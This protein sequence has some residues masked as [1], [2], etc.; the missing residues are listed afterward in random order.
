[1]EKRLTEAQHIALA[2]ELFEARRTRIPVRRPTLRFPDM[3]VED[4]YAV[5]RIWKDRLIAAGRQVVG[6]KIG[7]T[8]RAMQQASRINEPDYG[9]LLD[10]MVLDG[11]SAI[12]VGSFTFPRVEV[13][14]AFLIDAPLAGP[15]CTSHDVLKATRSIVPALEVLDSRI[16]IEGRTIVDTISDNAA[17]GLVVLGNSGMSVDSTDI[18]RIG[19]AL[20][21]NEIVEETGIAAGV[22]G[23]PAK[24]VAWL[25]NKLAQHGDHLAAGEIVLAGSFTRPVPVSAGDIVYADYG[26]LG[27][28]AVRFV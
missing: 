24:S 3:T 4:A 23:H 8:S 25:A 13:E 22:L 19:A 6:H 27:V 21:R 12:E 5:Q 9:V 28:I 15:G 1:M 18:A 10:D 26:P 7:L 11:H 16:E 17:C 14:L 2:D 20:Y